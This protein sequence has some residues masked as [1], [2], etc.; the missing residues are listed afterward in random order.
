MNSTGSFPR[1][2]HSH[3]VKSE[4]GL[5]SLHER[6]LTA[7][8]KIEF[9]PEPLRGGPAMHMMCYDPGGIRIEFIFAP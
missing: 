2:K 8:V 6:L 3:S 4:Q 9:S 7:G 1:E 5:K